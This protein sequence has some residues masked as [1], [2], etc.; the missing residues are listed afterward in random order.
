MWNNKYS[1]DA[2][3]CGTKTVLVVIIAVEILILAILMALSFNTINVNSRL[4]LPTSFHYFHILFSA[5]LMGFLLIFILGL[6]CCRFGYDFWKG[7]S[8]LTQP[9]INVLPTEQIRSDQIKSAD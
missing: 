9:I 5:V 1:C 4:G 3:G 8:T 6:T 2:G 7:V